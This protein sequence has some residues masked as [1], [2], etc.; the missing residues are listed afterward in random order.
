MES[1]QA[2]QVV[3]SGSAA[4]KTEAAAGLIVSSGM[5][6]QGPPGTEQSQGQARRKCSTKATH[7]CHVCGQAGL[8]IPMYSVTLRSCPTSER[9]P[10]IDHDQ[11]VLSLKVSLTPAVPSQKPCLVPTSDLDSSGGATGHEDR[12]RGFAALTKAKVWV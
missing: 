8:G 12:D 9:A 1:K 5:L 7:S 4:P 3:H 11:I 10:T 2:Q 6:A